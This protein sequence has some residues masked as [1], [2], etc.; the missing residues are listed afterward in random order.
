MIVIDASVWIS[1]LVQQDVNHSV[2]QPWLARTLTSGEVIVAPIL[3][4]SEVGG[5]IARRLDH[6]E[7]GEKA[8][9]QLLSV[10]TLRLVN[11]NHDSGIQSARIATRYRLRGA[12]AIYVTIA[13]QLNIPLVSWDQEQINRPAALITAYTP[14]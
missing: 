4:L 3:L 14:S 13:A 11:I 6:S 12:D 8:V 5:A 10:P 9:Q 2:T 7:L 1:F